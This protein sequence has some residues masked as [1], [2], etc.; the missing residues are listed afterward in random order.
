MNNNEC[1]WIETFMLCDWASAGSRT[2]LN[3][4][5]LECLSQNSKGAGGQARSLH[6]VAW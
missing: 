1:K 3:D 2:N 6:Y 5:S 4:G